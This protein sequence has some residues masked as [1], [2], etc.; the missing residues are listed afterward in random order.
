VAAL[1]VESDRVVMTSAANNGDGVMAVKSL[2][3]SL[4]AR[5]PAGS[6]FYASA[7]DIGPSLEVAVDMFLASVTADE[8][9][10][11]MFQ[12]AIDEFESTTGVEV[13]DLFTW[14][15]DVAVYV[16]WTAGAPVGGMIALT[17]DPTAA[18]EQI[19]A[20]VDAFEDVA[21]DSVTVERDGGVTRFIAGDGPEMEIAVGDGAVTFTVGDGEAARLAAIDASSSLGGEDRYTGAIASVGGSATDASVWLDLAGI[22]E[23]VAASAEGFEASMI[24]ANLEPL[25]HVVSATR[26]ENGIAISRIDLVLR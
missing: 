26:V 25:D 4:A 2:S 20:L 7:A 17:E 1:S 9:S 21:G 5:I 14:A 19:S 22:V 8:M 18:G 11:P 10:G 12:Q 3:E 23:A 6:L 24:L 16:D 15:G 13:R